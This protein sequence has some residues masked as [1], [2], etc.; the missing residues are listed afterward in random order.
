MSADNLPYQLDQSGHSNDW[1]DFDNSFDVGLGLDDPAPFNEFDLDF[2]NVDQMPSAFCAPALDMAD[3]QSPMDG[4]MEGPAHAI[5]EDGLIDP[6]LFDS[7]IDHAG[8]QGTQGYGVSTVESPFRHIVEAQ[9]A[10]DPSGLSNKAKRRDASIAIHLQRLHDP[11]ATEEFSSDSSTSFSS[12]SWSDFLRESVSPMPTR[13][14]AGPP[15]PTGDSTP[16]SSESEAPRGVEMVLDMNMNTTTNVPKKQ[17]PRSQA[18][19]DNYVKV[20]K[21]GACEKHRKQHKRVSFV[22]CG[23]LYWKID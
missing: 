3:Y 19:R 16:V 21:H 9:A 10:A 12:P 1:F 14:S 7:S 6:T 4:L 23:M 5:G 22:P 15:P 13:D 18:Q 8:A 17:K 11:S 2:A 20:R